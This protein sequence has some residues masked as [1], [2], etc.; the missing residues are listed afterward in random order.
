MPVIRSADVEFTPGLVENTRRR[1]L[2]SPDKGSGTII[3]GEAIMNLGTEFPT[4]IHRIEEMMVINKGTATA[5]LSDETHV[6]GQGD[7]IL[8]SA[9][10][11]HARQSQ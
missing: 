1:I 3:L 7:V 8:A 10:K 9:G 2:V 11:K 5:I 4:H 6:L